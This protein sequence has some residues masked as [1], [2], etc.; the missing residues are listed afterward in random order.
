M[1]TLRPSSPA[2]QATKLRIA[3][4]VAFCA[5]V[6]LALTNSAR[7]A[8]Q[9]PVSEFM[10]AKLKHSQRILAGLALE[11]FKEIASGAREIIELSQASSWQVFDTED[12][13]LH[14]ADFRRAA[15]ALE[16]AAKNRNLDGATLAYVDM[17]MKCVKCHKYVRGVRMANLDFEPFKSQ[18]ARLSSDASDGQSLE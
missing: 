10:K 12:Y 4:L 16:Y 13:L 2:K 7:T 18:L 5:L 11:D 3:A 6:A 8:Q 1:T 14:S 9:G 15:Q 17:T